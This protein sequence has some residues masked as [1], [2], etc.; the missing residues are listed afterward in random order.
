MPAAKKMAASASITKSH[1]RELL[2]ANV[3]GRNVRALQERVTGRR[4][5]VDQI[6]DPIVNADLPQVVAVRCHPPHRFSR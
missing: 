5:A 4:I 6:A 1:I 3:A 2:A